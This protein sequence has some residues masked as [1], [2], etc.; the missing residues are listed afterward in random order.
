MIQ[1]SAIRSLRLLRNSIL[2]I[3]CCSKTAQGAQ[4][5]WNVALPIFDVDSPT[6]AQ[7]SRAALRDVLKKLA[8]DSEAF[9]SY[10]LKGRSPRGS[11]DLISNEL[12][13]WMYDVTHQ[14][15][16]RLTR[17]GGYL[18][19]LVEP[20]GKWLWYIRDGKVWRREMSTG[21]EVL[22]ASPKRKVRL[23]LNWSR[24]DQHSL[25]VILGS[26]YDSIAELSLIINS[27]TA[28]N[29]SRTMIQKFIEISRSSPSG[30]V[31]DDA[32]EGKWD[33]LIKR[34]GSEFNERITND[35]FID[36][37][38]SWWGVDHIVYAS[39]RADP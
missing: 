32:F 7:S 14:R 12:D 8:I 11:S 1:F 9:D 36:R 20:G 13:I 24:A 22:V 31:F 5:S 29:L 10:Q 37:D 38:P 23:L 26:Q 27:L 2:I 25:F 4:P 15:H 33:V 16:Q 30:L 18:S 39:N 19:P 3:G 6:V 17:N 21:L 28:R 35:A 34:P